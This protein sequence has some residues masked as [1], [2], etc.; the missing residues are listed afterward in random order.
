[1]ICCNPN[2]LLKL[3]HVVSPRGGP[4]LVEICEH[5]YEAEDPAHPGYSLT[6]TDLF[7]AVGG[8]GEA[9]SIRHNKDQDTYE[10]FNYEHAEPYTNAAVVYEGTIGDVIA[11]AN[12]L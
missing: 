8:I 5:R 6:E 7:P 12:R 2:L 10:V 4:A 3:A 1:M 9:F 11:E